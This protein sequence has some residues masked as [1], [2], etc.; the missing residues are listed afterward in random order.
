M[1]IIYILIII[2]ENTT[3]IT[4]K[5][6]NILIKFKISTTYSSTPIKYIR[7]SIVNL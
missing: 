1:K 5:I 4:M 7:L 2:T 6:L 3:L